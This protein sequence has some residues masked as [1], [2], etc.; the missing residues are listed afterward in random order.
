MDPNAKQ[1]VIERV[2]QA[3]NI[4]VTVSTDPS[5]DQ[6][7][8]CIGLTLLLN[9]MDKHGTAVFSGRVPSTL[10]FLQPEKTLEPNTDSLRDFIISLDKA[11][12]DKLRYKVEDDVVRIFITPYRASLDE[13]DLV[14]S[15]GDFNVDVV[16]ALGVHSSEQIDQAIEAHG[17]I[18][19]DATVICLNAGEEPAETDIGQINWTDPQASSLCEMIVS[20]SEAFGTG[21]IDNQMATAFLTGIVAQTERF[22]NPKTSPKVM[23]MSAQLMAAGANQQLIAS[24]LEEPEPLPE[25]D[26]YQPPTQE[27]EGEEG[28][29]PDDQPAD[30]PADEHGT[31]QIPHDKDQPEEVRLDDSGKLYRE[32][33]DSETPLTTLPAPE[34]PS[35]EGESLPSDDYAS[36]DDSGAWAA[37]EPPPP[38]PDD[39][40]FG[41]DGV[42]PT[43]QQPPAPD[44]QPPPGPGSS[45]AKASV[46]DV[47]QVDFDSPQPS[48]LPSSPPPRPPTSGRKPLDNSGQPMLGGT[49]SANTKP[50]SYDNTTDPLSVNAH[51]GPILNRPEPQVLDYE[52]T[53][54]AQPVP[55]GS[56]SGDEREDQSEETPVK[57]QVDEPTTTFT[58]PNPQ[59]EVP[60]S[61]QP[62]SSL[63]KLEFNLDDAISPQPIVTPNP[64]QFDPTR[65]NIPQPDGT[66]SAPANQGT[67]LPQAEQPAPPVNETPA[68]PLNQSPPVSLD[69]QHY[70]DET[71]SEIEKEVGVDDHSEETLSQIEQELKA[72]QGVSGTS[73]PATPPSTTAD[74]PPPI[75][76]PPIMPSSLTNSPDDK[77]GGQGPNN[78]NGDSPLPA[79]GNAPS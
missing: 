67:D 75:V 60:Q 66:L 57:E 64:L 12:A 55:A 56:E 45:S 38:A 27:G 50:E 26:T 71:L 44:D 77:G 3:N 16:I 46:D 21:L 59:S 79:L 52:T 6:L 19:H 65:F 31:L 78:G 18:L 58:V 43:V 54:V 8:A 11:K 36:E 2:K 68:L 62:A 24:E 42:E 53:P 5:V 73:N 32:D 22:S 41:D 47:R 61:E 49:L 48:P 23:T 37:D 9:E 28:P 40:L 1:Q 13:S 30:I 14:F 39:Q 70:S 35:K 10:E 4:L 17:R 34:A 51:S 25:S 15:Q 20:I 29:P 76:P 72:Q 7:A 33:E 74:V 69:P 63:P